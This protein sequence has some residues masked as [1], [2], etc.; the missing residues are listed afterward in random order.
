MY[1]AYKRRSARAQSVL[2]HAA[3]LRLVS[4]FAHDGAPV[5]IRRGEP[6]LVRGVKRAK[7][8]ADWLGAL[9]EPDG[10]A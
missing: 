6:L 2:E 4:H 1:C 8:S 7:V 9:A 10:V 5:A 3:C